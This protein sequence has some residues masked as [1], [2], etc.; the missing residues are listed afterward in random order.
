MPSTNFIQWNPG[1]ANQETDA[2][3]SADT[4]RSG[5]AAVNSP[6]SSALA[7]KLFYQLSTFVTAFANVLVAK[8]F[9][10]NDGSASPGSALANLQAILTNLCITATDIDNALGYV[11]SDIKTTGG[12]RLQT[13]SNGG[14][15][16]VTFA[17][18]FASVPQVALGNENG[19][20]NIQP[21][22]LTRFGFNLNLAFGGQIVHYIAVGPA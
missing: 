13:G 14:G 20:C 19:S 22:S 1:A 11:P 5:G 4:Q 12:L 16:S 2:T 15:V 21:G 3:Y 7:N 8:G 9:S 10:P 6:F 17:T 18:A